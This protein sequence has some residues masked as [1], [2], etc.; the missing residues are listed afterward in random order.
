MAPGIVLAICSR[1]TASSLCGVQV[2]IVGAGFC[3]VLGNQ[4]MMKHNSCSSALGSFA[5]ALGKTLRFPA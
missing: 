1:A 4:G 2:S 3:P 5:G